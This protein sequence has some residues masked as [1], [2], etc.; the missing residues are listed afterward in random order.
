[1]VVLLL[2]V[3]VS[4][5]H[6]RVCFGSFLESSELFSCQRFAKKDGKEVPL[7]LKL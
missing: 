7:S 1:M 2:F 5:F 6:F 3:L 4:L